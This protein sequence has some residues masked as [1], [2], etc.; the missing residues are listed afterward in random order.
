MRNVGRR[1]GR[2]SW[3]EVADWYERYRDSLRGYLSLRTRSAHDAED[4][5]QEAFLHL[6]FAG[7]S[8]P[9]QN[10]KAFLFTTASNLLKDQLRR[11]HMRATETAVQAGDVDIP[12]FA[13]EPSGV[14]ESEQALARILS[15]L[16]QLHPSTREV[17][18][19]DRLQLWSHANIASRIGVTVSMVEK[20]MNYA[21]TAFEKSGFVQPRHCFSRRPKSRTRTARAS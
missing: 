15:T 20:H 6:W 12:D 11:A 5:V 10:P 4:I 21:M 7:S 14:L 1:P 3:G 2:A 16:I 18:L 17:F 13:S 9:I 19:L 8:G